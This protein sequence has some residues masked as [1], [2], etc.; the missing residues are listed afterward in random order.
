MREAFDSLGR[1][2]IIKALHGASPL[3]FH[4]V[5]ALWPLSATLHWSEETSED[6]PLKNQIVLPQGFALATA[7]RA[8]NMPCNVRGKPGTAF[9]LKPAIS[10]PLSKL[11]AIFC[12]ARTRIV[13]PGFHG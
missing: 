8:S 2:T 13:K 1:D 5:R 6:V 7:S 3:L 4:A 9:A 10:I 11:V 12:I